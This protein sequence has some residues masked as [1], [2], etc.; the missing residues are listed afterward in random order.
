MHL[1][2]DNNGDLHSMSDSTSENNDTRLSSSDSVS[3]DS[4]CERL[5]LHLI[6][7]NQIQITENDKRMRREKRELINNRNSA[8]RPSFNVVAKKLADSQ[9][10][11]DSMPDK[12]IQKPANGSNPDKKHIMNQMDK[13]TAYDMP[14]QDVSQERNPLS[15]TR[16]PTKWIFIDKKP[17]WNGKHFWKLMNVDCQCMITAFTW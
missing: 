2:I 15:K 16:K 3:E 6:P 12:N 8:L 9:K 4:S 1:R 17:Y 11:Q 10:V 7:R 14:M 5:P 13:K